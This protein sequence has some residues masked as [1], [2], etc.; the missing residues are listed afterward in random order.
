MRSEVLQVCART[1]LACKQLFRKV[2]SPDNHTRRNYPMRAVLALA[3][4]TLTSGALAQTAPMAPDIGAKFTA[5]TQAADYEKR[6]VMIPMLFP[7]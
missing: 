1:H 7:F 5:P 4:A 3:L 6:V 2:L